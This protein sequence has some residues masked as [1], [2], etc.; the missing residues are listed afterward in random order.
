MVKT[1][2]KVL[3][4]TACLAAMLTAT[5]IHSVLKTQTETVPASTVEEYVRWREVYR[6]GLTATPAEQGY[7][8]QMFVSNKAYVQRRNEEY[9]RRVVEEDLPKPAGPMFELNMFAD[10]SDEEFE[11]QY[12]G[13]AGS[14]KQEEEEVSALSEM[15]ENLPTKSTPNLGI[16][17]S[18]YVYTQGS[19]GSCW[20][21]AATGLAERKVF[22]AF[23]QRVKLSQQQLVDCDKVNDGCIGGLISDGLDYIKLVGVTSASEYPYVG[24]VTPCSASSKITKYLKGGLNPKTFD[25]NAKGVYDWV[26]ANN[27]AGGR[28]NGQAVRFVSK[29]DDIFSLASSDCYSRVNHAV[30]LIDASPDGSYVTML[31][32]WGTSW[33]FNGVKKIKPCSSYNYAGKGAQFYTY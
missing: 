15:Y 28:V 20:A 32:S 7:R 2:N 29:N 27:Y 3:M 33:G 22:T 26:S 23:G 12:L 19:C 1:S 6:A 21:F 10:L 25:F 13:G 18:Y 4:I 31:N 11:S 24:S 5:Y 14:G 9:A 30:I 17:H 8:L 16:A